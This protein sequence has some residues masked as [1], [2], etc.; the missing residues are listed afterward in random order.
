MP[1]DH[2]P[3]EDADHRHPDFPTGPKRPG[4][5][6]PPR[7]RGEDEAGH[8]DH[9]GHGRGG[10]GE[11]VALDGGQ[12]SVADSDSMA[13][14][15]SWAT[16]A[17]S[18]S[19]VSGRRVSTWSTRARKRVPE[20]GVVLVGGVVAPLAVL[21]SLALDLEGGGSELGGGPESGGR[22]PLTCP[23]FLSAGR[24]L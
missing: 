11:V 18:R 22:L 16:T 13:A 3:E 12:S 19:W 15:T 7:S 14:T 2:H 1:A 17:P 10:V 20:S 8:E 5:D 4:Q 24:R 6:E 21:R 9:D 23:S